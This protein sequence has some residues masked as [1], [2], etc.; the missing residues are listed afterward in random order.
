M[1]AREKAEDTEKDGGAAFS[2]VTRAGFI[3]HRRRVHRPD[4]SIETSNVRVEYRRFFVNISRPARSARF[5]L[6]RRD[7]REIPVSRA[8]NLV[9][10]G[11]RIAREKNEER[12]SDFQ[13]LIRIFKLASKEAGVPG[14][15]RANA[16]LLERVGEWQRCVFTARQAGAGEGGTSKERGEISRRCTKGKKIANAEAEPRSAGL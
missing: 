7:L 15:T 1:R 11:R 8:G 9:V 16:R 3:D 13:D 4:D 2:G 14:E 10:G 12:I 6:P 5:H